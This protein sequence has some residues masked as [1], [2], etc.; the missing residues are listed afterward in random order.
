MKNK[1]DEEII[2]SI[3]VGDIKDVANQVLERR[4]TRKELLMVS[5]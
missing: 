3:N 2:Y 1:T 5:W 4:L